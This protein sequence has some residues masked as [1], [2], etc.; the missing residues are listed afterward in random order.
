MDYLEKKLIKSFFNNGGYV[1][2]FTNSTFDEFT[3]YYIGRSIRREYGLSK[4]KTLEKFVDME[5]ETDGIKLLIKFFEHYEMMNKNSDDITQ[6]MLDY[7][8]RVK[9]ILDKEL[10]LLKEKDKH[11]FFESEFVKNVDSDYIKKQSQLIIDAIKDAPS[12]AIGKSKELLETCFKYILDDL[13]IAYS[14]DETVLTLRKKVFKEL[15]LD[16][17]DNLSAKSSRD[18]QQVLSGLT[19]II[20]GINGLRN[21]KGSGHGKEKNFEE[22]PPRYAMLVVNSMVAIVN[23]TWETY[24]CLY[25]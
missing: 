20:Q 24:E 23:F 2:D 21:E 25:K 9:L 8:P 17:K 22:L 12:D 13:E 7:A 6:Y 5:L 15:N 3:E 19:Q 4:G 14:K 16:S 11:V 1:L 18:V 10:A